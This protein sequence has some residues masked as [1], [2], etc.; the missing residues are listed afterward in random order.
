MV[1]YTTAYNALIQARLLDLCTLN[2]RFLFRW[3][4]QKMNIYR[5][6]KYVHKS[7]SLA[8]ISA[9]SST[10]NHHPFMSMLINKAKCLP[11]IEL[12][13]HSKDLYS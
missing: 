8:C 6:L 3:F 13:I 5:N 4:N 12:V 11:F 9:L 1:I 2:S 10:A 7:S